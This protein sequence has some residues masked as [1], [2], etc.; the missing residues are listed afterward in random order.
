MSAW[1]MPRRSRRWVIRAL[2]LAIV[3]GAVFGAIL[4]GGPGPQIPGQQITDG[5]VDGVVA[6][7]DSS[8]P[9]DDIF[10]AQFCGGV[11]IAPTK[12]LT[13]AHCVAGLR[14][15]AV[16][17]QLG[18]WNLCRASP[19]DGV[20]Y[21]CRLR[22]VGA[23]LV[24]QES[25]QVSLATVVGRSFASASMICATPVASDADACLGDSGGP[26]IVDGGPTDGELVGVVSW[27]VGCDARF[28]GVYARA[29]AFDE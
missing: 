24:S 29:D 11:L 10:D 26:L 3:W 17:V 14:P 4:H 2:A 27:G 12:I 28:P 7:V 6:L 9:L 15:E 25:C 20:P 1:P 5:P 22:R 21:D 18:A 23:L 16:A 8:A 13:A 19:V